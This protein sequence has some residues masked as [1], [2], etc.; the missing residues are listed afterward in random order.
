MQTRGKKQ[1]K[2]PKKGRKQKPSRAGNLPTGE[3]ELHG[4]AENPE[5][6]QETMEVDDSALV[7]AC[8][9]TKDAHA[10]A[11]ITMDALGDGGLPDPNQEIGA[12][13]IANL[14]AAE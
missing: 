14:A 6:A 3:D 8:L 4:P 1:T 9:A 10:K 13:T 7:K 2:E 11:R 12:D 5:M